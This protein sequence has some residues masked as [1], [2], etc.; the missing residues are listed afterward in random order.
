MTTETQ[1]DKTNSRRRLLFTPQQHE[2]APTPRT[3][4]IHKITFYN[5]CYQIQSLFRGL[6]AFFC[7]QTQGTSICIRHASTPDVRF[8]AVKQLSY[9]SPGCT[10]CYNAGTVHVCM[11]TCMCVCVCVCVYVCVCVRVC[12]CVSV[13]CCRVASYAKVIS[14]WPSTVAT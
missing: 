5:T 14:Y 9:S 6:L 4:D 12:V 2:H 8:H 11:C 10:C 3:H 13:S 1:L 7:A